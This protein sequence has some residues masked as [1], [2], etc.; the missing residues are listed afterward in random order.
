V[1]S[2]E[3][4]RENFCNGLDGKTLFSALNCMYTMTLNEIEVVLKVSAHTEQR[5]TVNKS[6][7]LLTAQNDDFREINKLQ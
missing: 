1:N 4:D 2:A 3:E 5:G 6:S 7:V